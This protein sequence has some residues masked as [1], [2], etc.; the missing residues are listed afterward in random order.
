[1]NH[2][3]SSDL[4][5]LSG[6][7]DM[8]AAAQACFADGN[9]TDTETLCRQVLQANAVDSEAIR[10]LGRIAH[11]T[12]HLDQAVALLK[13]SIDLGS[14][15]AESLFILANTL[16]DLDDTAG[17]IEAYRQA[18]EIDPDFT[19]AGVNLANSLLSTG[20]YDEAAA[21]STTTLSSHPDNVAALSNLGQ[22]EM[23]LGNL[24]D[25]EAALSKACKLA[26]GNS[27][28][29]NNLG[30]VRQLL[31]NVDDALA[32]FRS[33][34]KSDA[35]CQLAERNLLVAVLN[36]PEMDS[37]T[38][39]DE[40]RK[41]G[42]RHRRRSSE[43]IDYK[44]R[45]RTPHRKLRIGYLSSDFR[46]HPVGRNVFPLIEHHDPN[47]TEVHLYSVAETHDRMSDKFS[48][49]RHHWHDASQL[50]DHQVAEKIRGDEIDVMV[51]LAGRFN[52]NRPQV[53]AHRAAPIQVSFHDCATSGLAEMDY[54]LTDDILHPADTSEKFTESLYRLPNFYQFSLPEYAPLVAPPPVL[55]NGHITFGSFSKPEKLNHRV[56][57]LWSRILSAVPDAELIFK[58]QNFYGDPRIKDT[59][60]RKFAAHGISPERI[61]LVSSNDSAQ[62]HLAL[63]SQVDIA[64]DPLPFNGATTT[65]EAMYMGVPVVALAGQHFVDRVAANLLTRC[66]LT[67]LVA[68]DTN[69][70]M[71]IAV[72]LS[73]NVP[74]LKNRRA[75]TREKLIRSPLCNGTEYAQQ[76]E[77]AYRD[78]WHRWCQNSAR[79]S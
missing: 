49:L 40:H 52:L 11:Q 33:A 54:W 69:A 76:I 48:S 23:K 15:N 44:D 79:P 3:Q 16:F 31:G 68:E 30:V 57:E 61:L 2:I 41:I 17:A 60:R 1:M 55:H 20:E 75:V 39:F 36:Q 71:D 38:L 53:A 67:D 47:N 64:L 77:A 34:L 62:D 26:P 32:D 7:H 37:E 5:A 13:R 24:P 46:D 8:L 58:Y 18:L 9:L 29:M 51:Y 27:E 25:A 45:D 43:M 4:A 59:W 65:F 42:A 22:A 73:E 63:Y 70:Y 28:L 21:L 72:R 74:Q 50:S 35:N 14:D 6:E 78:M 10:L 66:G 19:E 56:I 12:G